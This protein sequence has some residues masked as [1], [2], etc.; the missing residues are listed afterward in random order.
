ML[1][2]SRDTKSWYLD[3]D[4]LS[5]VDTTLIDFVRKNAGNSILDLGCGPGGYSAIL[6]KKGFSVTALDVNEKYVK[7]A[8]SLG[9]SAQ[10]YDGNTIPLPDASVDTVVMIEVLEHVPNPVALLAEVA[11]VARHGLIATVP[12]CTTSFNGG[13]VVYEHMLDTDHKNF[14]TKATFTELLEKIFDSVQVDEI[15]PVDRKIA[16][17]I[18]PPWLFFLYRAALSLGVAKQNHY[19]RLAATTF[20]RKQAA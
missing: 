11:R 8:Q 2:S 4:P 7:I 1:A 3:V 9:V 13:Q 14:F 15:V 12:N 5:V 20:G 19:F 16:R 17:Q 6:Q 18:L 10:L